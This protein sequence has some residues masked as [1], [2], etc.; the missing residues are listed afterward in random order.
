MLCCS[1]FDKLA[2]RK[3]VFGSFFKETKCVVSQAI[4]ILPNVSFLS[5]LA[6]NLKNDGQYTADC[7][8]GEEQNGFID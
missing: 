4:H 1:S 2:A 3:A 6:D 5:V 7:D 8:S